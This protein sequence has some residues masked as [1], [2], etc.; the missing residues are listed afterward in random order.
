MDKKIE[1]NTYIRTGNSLWNKI[2]KRQLDGYSLITNSNLKDKLRRVYH[3]SN[4]IELGM[5]IACYNY[6]YKT[7]LMYKMSKNA[8]SSS[9]QT[10]KVSDCSLIS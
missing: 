5:V 2:S 3:Q 10:Q 9:K 8:R 4:K 1:N 7:P 6:N